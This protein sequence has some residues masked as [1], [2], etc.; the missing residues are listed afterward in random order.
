[1]F[2]DITDIV[3]A[4][5]IL[6]RREHIWSR[7]DYSFCNN[8]TELFQHNFIFYFRASSSQ[9]AIHNVR[10]LRITLVTKVLRQIFE[11]FKTDVTKLTTHSRQ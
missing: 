2:P 9:T 7:Q 6:G 10:M 5:S 3:W 11:Q 1:M 4:V 8:K